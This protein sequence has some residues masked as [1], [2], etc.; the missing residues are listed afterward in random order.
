[1][2]HHSPSSHLASAT[3]AQAPSLAT[4]LTLICA[5][6]AAMPA[7]AATSGYSETWGSGNG[8]LHGWF[9]NT[10]GSAVSNPGFAGNPDG[11]LLTRVGSGGFPIGA[12]TDLAA[13][14]GSFSSGQL[15]TATFDLTGGFNADT[16]SDISLRLRYQ[17]GSHNGWQYTVGGALDSSWKTFSVTFDPSWTDAEAKAHGWRT[18]LANG[19]GS[20]SWAQTLGD[21]YTTEVRIT[22]SASDYR[23][24]L[25]NFSLTA[26]PVPEPATGLMALAGCLVAAAT[27]KRRR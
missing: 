7:A 10:T 5:L 27:L 1:M 8:D 14:T 24:G 20:V 13:A 11:F 12:A 6:A 2:N 25:D 15:W 22:G 16:I 19:F 23:V 21:V 3:T 18:D 26:A 4:A 9:A 17:D